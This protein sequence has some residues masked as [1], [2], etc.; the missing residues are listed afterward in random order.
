MPSIGHKI[1]V[2]MVPCTQA[3]FGKACCGS[4]HAYHAGALAYNVNQN[5]ALTVN[6]KLPSTGVLIGGSYQDQFLAVRAGS[7]RSPHLHISGLSLA[8][9]WRPRPEQPGQP[10]GTSIQPRAL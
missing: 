4:E 6:F 5:T 3:T 2:M 7:R 8:A 10:G 1:L 9:A